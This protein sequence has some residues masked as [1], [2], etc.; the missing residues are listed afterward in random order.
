MCFVADRLYVKC[1]ITSGANLLYLIVMHTTY[2]NKT[3]RIWIWHK[4][5]GIVG[6]KSTTTREDYFSRSALDT[7]NVPMHFTCVTWRSNHAKWKKK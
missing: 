2:S 3:I 5:Y 6:T 4:F 1:E 7:I